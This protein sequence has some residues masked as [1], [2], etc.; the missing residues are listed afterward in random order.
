MRYGFRS[1][2]AGSILGFAIINAPVAFLGVTSALFLPRRIILPLSSILFMAFGVYLFTREGICETGEV[3]GEGNR[4]FLAA[5]L[6]IF[7]AELGDKTQIATFILASR[8]RD[9]LSVYGGVMLGLS[10]S[11]LIGISLGKR[12]C[13]LLPHRTLSYLSGALFFGIGLYT[14]LG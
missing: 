1:V 2:L 8:F 7:V 3:K 13:T 6:S 4:G 5:L 11:V 14:L 10:L 9:F 12:I